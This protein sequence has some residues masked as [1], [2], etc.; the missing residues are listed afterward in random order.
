MLWRVEAGI[1]R[2]GEKAIGADGIEEGLCLAGRIEAG[3]VK[4][5]WTRESIILTLR[6]LAESGQDVSLKAIRRDR[7]SLYQAS[8]RYFRNSMD[9]YEAAGISIKALE[10]MP[11]EPEIL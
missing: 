3:M 5:K 1:S 7:A 8:R 6:E 4:R 2:P 11:S 9:M 10:R